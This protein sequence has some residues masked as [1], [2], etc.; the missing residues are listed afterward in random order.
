MLLFFNNYC[1]VSDVKNIASVPGPACEP[2]IGPMLEITG[3]IDKPFSIND[4]RRFASSIQ[5]A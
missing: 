5:S 4:A 1:L 3:F 2:T